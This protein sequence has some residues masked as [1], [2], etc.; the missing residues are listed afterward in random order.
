VYVG[1]LVPKAYNTT[2]EDVLQ[3]LRFF[4][5]TGYPKRY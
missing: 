3:P 2:F 4:S 5:Q 1:K